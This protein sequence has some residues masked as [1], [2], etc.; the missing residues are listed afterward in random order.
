MFRQ[1]ISAVTL[2]AASGAIAQDMDWQADIDRLTELADAYQAYAEKIEGGSVWIGVANYGIDTEKHRCAILGR[3]LGHEDVVSDLQQMTFPPMDG[4]SDPFDLAL[5]ATSLSNWSGEA[6]AALNADHAERVNRWNLDCAGNM[7][8][9]ASARMANAAPEA[10]FDFDDKFNTGRLTVYGDIDSGFFDRFV[11]E[12]DRHDTVKEV[13]LGSGGGSVKDAQLAGREIRR[14]RLNTTL[15]G[16]CYSACPLVFAGGVERTIWANVRHDFGFHRL[17]LQDGTALPDDHPFY[18]LIADYLT[19]MG[20]DPGIYIGWM[21][22]AGPDDLYTPE[23]WDICDPVL[24][25]FVQRI[26]K[27]GKRF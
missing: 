15:H 20:V 3:M 9:P 7:G 26:C 27:D 4:T 2:F 17:S 21:L 1:I 23:P 14:R 8:I 16:N 6:Q 22:K 24:A 10:Q 25:T 18:G 19:E 12:L 11:A 13:L 5:F